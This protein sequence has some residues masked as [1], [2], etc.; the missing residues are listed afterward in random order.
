MCTLV[1]EVEVGG[2]IASQTPG[3]V[4]DR[5]IKCGVGHTSYPTW[6]YIIHHR[7]TESGTWLREREPC[8][9]CT[10]NN[11]H[12]VCLLAC[13]P[14]RVASYRPCRSTPTMKTSTP[15]SPGAP[16]RRRPQTP[17]RR[18]RP[19]CR[20]PQRH[21]SR[22]TLSRPPAHDSR[23]TQTSSPRSSRSFCPWS[24]RALTRSS[25]LGR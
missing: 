20:R 6:A 9:C 16:S 13:S 22:P 10:Y 1:G 19:R 25:E 18:S 7:T 14:R 15:R 12:P 4:L 23:T 2:D 17:F 8:R 5:G 24:S 3:A 21:Q 11:R